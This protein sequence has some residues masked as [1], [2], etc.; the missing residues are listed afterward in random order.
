M[1]YG[2][3]SNPKQT[4]ASDSDRNIN[5]AS[6]NIQLDS[7]MLCDRFPPPEGYELIGHSAG[8]GE[9]LSHIKLLPGKS[10]VHLYNGELKSNQ[11][12]HVAVLDISVGDKDLQQCADAVM[13]LR[14]EYLYQKA[15]F[16]L[17][18]FNFTNG[19]CCDYQHW[20]DGFRVQINDNHCNWQKTA[21]PSTSRKDFEKYLET[22][23]SYA[24]TMSLEKELSPTPIQ[25]IQPGDVFIH[26]GSPG[27]A[28]IVLQVA[29]N[30]NSDER[31]FLL[32]QSYM[33]AQEIHILKNPNN[34]NLSPWY[35]IPDGQVLETPEWTFQTTELRRFIE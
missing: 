18:K 19:F 28:V 3:S 26:G 32:A 20:K 34:E 30:K 27:H 2:C 24:G 22:V 8:F 13:R 9:Y 25:K 23:F 33:P 12:V 14:A 31:M 17:L 21:A 5:H 10:K 4:T 7:A 29:K 16:N 6:L 1:L 35:Q 15:A 11:Q